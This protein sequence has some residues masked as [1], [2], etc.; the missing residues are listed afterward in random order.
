MVAIVEAVRICQHIV[1][2]YFRF[3]FLEL[4]DLGFACSQGGYIP[5]DSGVVH[6]DDRL[7]C[8]SVIGSIVHREH[9]FEVEMF[10]EV[11][12]TVDITGR[13]VVLGFGGVC[14]QTDVYHWIVDLCFLKFRQCTV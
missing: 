5:A 14:S 10:Q 6:F 1:T 4:A 13:P 11:H 12:F 2:L 9:R 3:I 8:P 7:V